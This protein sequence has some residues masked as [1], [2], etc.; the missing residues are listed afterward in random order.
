MQQQQHPHLIHSSAA[1]ELHRI[2]VR[3][4]SRGATVGEVLGRGTANQQQVSLKYLL[5]ARRSTTFPSQAPMTSRAA[6]PSCA[7]QGPSLSLRRF[8]SGRNPDLHQRHLV[9]ATTSPSNP[10]KQQ[11]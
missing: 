10:V 2:N 9:A 1:V 8:W 3:S 7:L 6:Q 4:L 11:Y 5:V